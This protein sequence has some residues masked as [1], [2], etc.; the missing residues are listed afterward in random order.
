MEDRL[1]SASRVMANGQGYS[2][3]GNCCTELQIVTICG[4]ASRIATV[5]PW[6]SAMARVRLLCVSRRSALMAH[7][8]RVA[9]LSIGV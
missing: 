6:K 5:G 1:T 7:L 4:V 2:Q 9:S 8:C 3:C